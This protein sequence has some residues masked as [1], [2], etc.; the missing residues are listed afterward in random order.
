MPKSHTSPRKRG[1]QPGNANARKHGFYA[2][3]FTRIEDDRLDTSVKGE[4]FDEE[5]LLRVMIAR[6]VESMKDRQMPHEELVVALRAVSLAIGRIESLHRSRKV[7]Y[8][9]G[10]SLQEALDELKYLPLEEV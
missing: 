3:S 4:F 7:I 2:Q 10:T 6:T 5:H 9:R 1:G 8:D